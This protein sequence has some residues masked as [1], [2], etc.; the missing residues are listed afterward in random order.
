M[1]GQTLALLQTMDSKQWFFPCDEQGNVTDWRD[2]DMHL[3]PNGEIA[4][5]GHELT[6]K[7][8]AD[9]TV[10]NNYEIVEAVK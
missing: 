7:V 9:V 5:M 4:K 1:F 8:W 3:Y 2:L 10:N 6:C